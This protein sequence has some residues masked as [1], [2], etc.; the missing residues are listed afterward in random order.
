MAESNCAT[1]AFRAK[2][3]TI[4]NLFWAESGAGMLTGAL[5]GNLI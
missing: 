2:Y 4:P 1:C 3:E 5:A